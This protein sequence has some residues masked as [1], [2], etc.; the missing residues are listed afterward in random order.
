MTATFT[1]FIELYA[2]RLL[3]LHRSS[4]TLKNYRHNAHKFARSCQDVL[5]IDD[6]RRLAPTHFA[7]FVAYLREQGI[8]IQR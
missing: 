4:A 8:R 7:A 6:P 5:S 2:E 3:S 1:G